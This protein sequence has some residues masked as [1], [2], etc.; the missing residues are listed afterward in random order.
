MNFG[1]VTKIAS[2]L[3]KYKLARAGL[4]KPPLPLF[5]NF[6][7]TNR[8]Q[9]RCT[10]C[11]IWKLYKEK[12]QLR[13]KEFQLWEIE[14][15]FNSMGYIYTLAIC[16]GEPFLRKDLPEIGRLANKYLKPD[17]IHSPTNCLA[18]K[19]IEDG[20]LGLLQN[21]NKN[22][23]LTIKLSIDGVGKV[24]DK[25]R[26][27]KGN[28]KKVL[29]THDRL[30][31][32]RKTNPNLYVDAGATIS[33]NNLEHLKELNK[34]VNKNLR[35]DNFLYE[36]ADT[37]AELFNVN[38]KFKE[39]VNKEFKNMM[40]DLKITPKGKEYSQVVDFLC[41]R[42]IE[43]MKK[44]RRLSKIIQAFRLVY[45]KR[46]AKVMTNRKRYVPCYAGI[47]NAHINPWGGLWICNV[48][49]FKKEIGNL[50]DYN[51]N[52]KKIWCS[53]EAN[54]IRGWV[55]GNHCFCPLAGQ[56]FL[57]TILT[58]KELLKALWYYLIF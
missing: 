53:K 4:I 38:L 28:F 33:I 5:L 32:I 21:I 6:S 36:I 34:Y 42:T 12:P 54:K 13:K 40:N 48:Q 25:I 2:R 19:K 41:K 50:R 1:N 27:V 44:V 16:G 47:S 20:V 3:M 58:P 18:P 23:A 11:N 51:Y 15:I 14:K 45:Y 24:H 26:G 39:N 35:L 49:A 43:E 29:E 8:C 37:R 10:T 57:D 17:V 9:S 31:E 46:S 22:T 7:I 55:K 52:F 56:G 30:I